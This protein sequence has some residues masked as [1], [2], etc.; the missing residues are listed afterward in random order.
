MLVVSH[1]AASE[2]RL[3]QQADDDNDGDN[4]TQTEHLNGRRRIKASTRGERWTVTINTHT[5]TSR[6]KTLRLYGASIA[7]CMCIYRTVNTVRKKS[8]AGFIHKHSGAGSDMSKVTA[9]KPFYT[10]FIAKYSTISRSCF[11]FI[12][13]DLLQLGTLYF[14]PMLVH[15]SL[16]CLTSQTFYSL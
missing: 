4:K 5:H 8:C 16:W 10:V 1:A 12:W 6:Y 7:E 9:F 14:Q 11:R 3:Q 15:W 13:A 2:L